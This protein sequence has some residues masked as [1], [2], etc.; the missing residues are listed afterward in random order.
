ML[1]KVKLS[2]GITSNRFDSEITDNIATALADMG[3]TSDIT[4]LDDTDSLIAKAVTTY[5]VW[6][7][8]LLHGNAD[9][10]DKFKKSYDE[11]KKTLLMAS[12][13]TTWSA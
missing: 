8:N 5:C 4:N 11:Q 13:Y 6:Q 1:E 3:H 10:A 9:L 2:L 7:H 12:G